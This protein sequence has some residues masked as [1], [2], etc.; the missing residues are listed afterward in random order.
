MTATDQGGQSD[1]V[2]VT[3]NVTDVNEP[4]AAENDTAMTAEDAAVNID[5][6]ANDSDPET[7]ADDLRVRVVTQPL[8]GRVTIGGDKTFTYTPDANYHG[9]DTFTY[10]VS[11]GSLEDEASVSITVVAVNDAPAFASETT[12][13][14]V[15]ESARPGDNVGP[16]IVASGRRR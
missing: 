15:S 1:T 2:L 13:R 6:L 3:I 5:V 8:N 7:P 9:D 10:A 12:V 16:P 14:S 11:D 4:P